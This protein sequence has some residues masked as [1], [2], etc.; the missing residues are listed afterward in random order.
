MVG[1]CDHECDGCFKGSKSCREP[2]G[3]GE[4]SVEMAVKAEWD[5]NGRND[6][7]GLLKNSRCPEA[8]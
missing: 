8:G 1:H 4:G 5:S 6:T 3:T 7:P 2:K